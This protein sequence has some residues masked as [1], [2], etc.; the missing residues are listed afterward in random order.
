MKKFTLRHSDKLVGIFVLAG[1]LFLVGSLAFVGINKRWFKSDLQYRS[2]FITAKGL[3]PGLELELHGFAIGRIK[4]LHL[5]NDNH[6]EVVLTIFNEYADRI[7]ENSVIHLAVS[8]LGFG[9]SLVLYPGTEPGA[10]LPAGSSIPSTDLALG[11]R[12]VAEGLVQRPKRGDEVSGLLESLPPLMGQVEEFVGSLNRLTSRMDQRLMGTENHPSEGLLGT[13]G[14]TLDGVDST[15]RQFGQVAVRLDSMTIQ[16]NLMLKSMAVFTS[17]LENPQGLV[18]TLL[19][20]EGSVGQLFHD[21]AELYN[22]LNDI[23]GELHALSLFL[24]SSTPEIAVLLEEA[25]EAMAESEKVMEGLKNNPLLRGGITQE[26]ESN[27]VFEGYRQEV[28]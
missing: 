4:S 14:G 1:T 25:T 2:Q 9:S 16:L 27:S 7:V 12:L 13:V 19:G 20:E 11:R 22:R 28:R 18:P 17:H 8:P 3:N 6:V 26:T 5:Q 23:T 21:N 15:T 10:T 24:N